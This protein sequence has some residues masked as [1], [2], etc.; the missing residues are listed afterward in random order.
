M[1]R[2]A[3]KTHH[4]KTLRAEKADLVAFRET[5]RKIEVP[6]GA[7]ILRMVDQVKPLVGGGTQ[8]L[9]A[10]R[11]NFA[12]HDRVIILTDEQAFADARA[13]K[14]PGQDVKVPIFTFN[15]AG[16]KAGHLPSGGLN[17]YTFGGLTDQGFLAIEL[18]ER[19]QDATWPF[20]AEK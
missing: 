9:K 7:S 16:Y 4:F 3:C 17:R 15:L 19:G 8:T 2:Q 11:E 1:G 20:L 10:L 6:K 12:G 18:L 13:G 14:T 5:S